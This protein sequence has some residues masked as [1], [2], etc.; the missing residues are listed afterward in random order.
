MKSQDIL[1][2][3]FNFGAF[4]AFEYFGAHI[5]TKTIQ[6]VR[7]QGVM[8]R[9]YAP[10]ATQVSVIGDF[11][12]WTP[13]KHVM[14][15]VHEYGIYELFISGL[16]PGTTYKYAFK[17][18]HGVLVHK[19]DPYGFASELRPKTASVVTEQ[20][21]RWKDQK[22]LANRSRNLDQPLSIYE[23]HLGS[24][25][26]PSDHEFYS[27]EEIADQLI[28][29]VIDHGFTHIELM[30]ITQ[31]P[32]DGSWGY[33]ATGFL[34][35]DSRYGTVKQFKTMIDRFHQAGIGVILD[36]VLVHFANDGFG[37]FEFDGTKLYE[38]FDPQRTFSQWGSPQFDLSKPVVRSL[39]FSGVNYFLENF[40]IDG[41]R[42]D[43]VSNIVYWD[44]NAQR[45]DNSGGIAFLKD[46]NYFVHQYHPNVM[47]IAEDSTAFSGV[48]RPV[49]DG[50]LGFDYKWDMGWMNDTLKFYGKDPVF[51]YYDHHQLTFSMHYFYSDRFLLPLSHDEVVHGKGTILNKMWGNYDEKF[52]LVR[53]LYTYQYLH[54]GKKLNF[55][56]NEFASFDEWDEKKSLPW[57][58]TNYPKHD[59]IRQLFKDLNQL[60]RQEKVLYHDEYNPVNFRW[61]MV[62]NAYDSVYAFQRKIGD[63]LIICVF[64]MKGNYYNDYDIGVEEPGI[65]QEVLNSDDKKYSGWHHIQN[66]VIHT[67]ARPGIENKPYRLTIKLGS[68]AA[69]VL[70]RMKV[71]N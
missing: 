47:M 24:W 58:F 64:N 15:L 43:A 14:Q 21:Y 42:I 37:L 59:S 38:Y 10:N 16:K 2:H 1:Q 71:E 12:Q 68:F 50:G 28:P 67:Q 39:L 35:V 19:A 4:S 3:F 33:Q 54:P 18:A 17:N 70:K 62:N 44:G 27:Y 49:G 8:F 30:P 46:L 9:L 31:H 57:F 6:G 7:S 20:K 11:N 69:I 63:E 60:Y 52:A 34:A 66:G 45:G 29:Y 41:I 53:N 40:H 61:L 55:M 51:K 65:Y 22:Y 23:V 48:T 36:Y 25:K 56:S 13:T 32:F 26:K 5:I